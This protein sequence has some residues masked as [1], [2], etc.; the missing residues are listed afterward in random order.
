MPTDPFEVL[1]KIF[2]PK[3]VVSQENDF[4]RV[5]RL[6]YSDRRLFYKQSLSI[7]F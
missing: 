6:A 2:K 3:T 7:L 1:K 4:Y 5:Y